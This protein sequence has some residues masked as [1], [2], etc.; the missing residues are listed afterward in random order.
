[1]E[2]IDKKGNK[3]TAYKFDAIRNL[4]HNQENLAT[5]SNKFV[6]FLTI[7]CSFDGKELASYLDPNNNAN[8]ANIQEYIKKI[9]KDKKGH[10]R[11]A[12]L[13]RLFTIHKLAEQF[14]TF[15]FV[16]HFLPTIFYQGDGDTT[17]LHFTVL[18][19]KPDEATNTPW[20]QRLEDLIENEFIQ[21]QNTNLADINPV[22]IF[23]T[24]DTFKKHWQKN[25]K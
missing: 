19:V 12:L 11:N 2:F 23:S 13:L 16:P 15:K 9:R 17:L 14:R 20:L 10:V 22:N 3:K 8:P 4:L 1:M 5:S 18:G 21:P 6:F 25:K 7:H 24:S